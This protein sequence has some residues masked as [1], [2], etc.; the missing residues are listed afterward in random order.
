[1]RSFP[2]PQTLL[3][4]TNPRGWGGQSIPEITFFLSKYQNRLRMSGKKWRLA[5]LFLQPKPSIISIFVNSRLPCCANLVSSHGFRHLRQPNYGSAGSTIPSV[6]SSVMD[7]LV[8][9]Y[10]ETESRNCPARFA[11]SVI[12]LGNGSSPFLGQPYFHQS[13]AAIF[14]NLAL[15]L[16]TVGLFLVGIGMIIGLF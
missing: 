6:L 14:R 9:T 15:M 5:I 16:I 2:G 12:L 3:R 11:I 10:P 7:F 4:E 8:S 1:M 13:K